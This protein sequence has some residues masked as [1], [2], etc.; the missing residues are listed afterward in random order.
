MGGEAGGGEGGV[1]ALGDEGA[2]V[3][4]HRLGVVVELHLHDRV[5]AVLADQ[6]GGRGR[7]GHGP[8][9]LVLGAARGELGL[10]LLELGA[11][12]LELGAALGELLAQAGDGRVVRVRRLELRKERL[13]AGELALGLRRAA[14][15][16]RRARA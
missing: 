8:A 9:V 6:A 16:R 15:G 10:A 11:A 2:V 13:A 7:R 5:A 1:A 3:D 12:L 4:R 14:P